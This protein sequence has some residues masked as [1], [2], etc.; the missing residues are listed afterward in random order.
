MELADLFYTMELLIL[1]QINYKWQEC[2][3]GTLNLTAID[4]TKSENK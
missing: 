1:L 3:I 4:F 2:L